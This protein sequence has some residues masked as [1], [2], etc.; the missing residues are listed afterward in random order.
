[1]KCQATTQDP[2]K[3]AKDMAK[4]AKK[5]TNK[6]THTFAGTLSRWAE[7]LSLPTPE[8][9]PGEKDTISQGGTVHTAQGMSR[10]RGRLALEGDPQREGPEPGAAAPVANG[11]TCT[12]GE[13]ER[14]LWLCGVE[15]PE[16]SGGLIE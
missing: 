16:A 14:D 1:M 10:G 11:T 13:R 3:H 2:D 8:G 15:K 5:A 6:A 7:R 4:T 12:T 9:L